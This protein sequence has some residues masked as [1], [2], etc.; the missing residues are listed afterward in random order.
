MIKHDRYPQSN[1]ANAVKEAAADARE[2]SQEAIQRTEDFVHHHPG[3]SA[4]VVF[5]LGLGL[6]A[7]MVSALG[8]PRRNWYDD[9]IP[10]WVSRDQIAKYIP[11]AIRQRVA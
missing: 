8:R 5:G 11:D 3:T 1:A 7:L 10:T 4:L 9:Y 6:G 2:C